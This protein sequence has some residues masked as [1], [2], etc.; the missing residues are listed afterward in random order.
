M[1]AVLLTGAVVLALLGLPL[2]LVILAITLLGQD[3]VGLQAPVIFVEIFDRITDNPI[4][5]T[6]PLFAH[7]GFVLSESRAPER[8]VELS[9]SALGFL[10]GGSSLVALFACALFTAFTGASGVT[11]IALGGLLLPLL[12]QER[13]SERFSLG[14]LTTGGSLGLLFPPSLPLIIFALIASNIAPVPVETLFIAGFVPGLLLLLALGLYGSVVGAR[15]PRQ[16]RTPFQPARVL[17]AVRAAAFELPVPV[18]V[19]GGIFGGFL[20]LAQAAAAVALYVSFVEVYVYRDLDVRK[21]GKV[22]VE[23]M[24]MV[25]GVLIIIMAALAMTNLLT[26]Q[27]IPRRILEAMRGHLTSPLAFLLFLNLF[28]LAV[29][30]LMDIFSAILVVVPL[31]LP[32][33]LDFGIDPVHLGI[34]ILANLEIGYSTPPV[35]I[36]LFIASLRFRRPVVALYSASLPFLGIL[37]VCLGFITYLP[38][39]S[40]GLVR[41]LEGTSSVEVAW[42]RRSERGTVA[43]EATLRWGLRT[44]EGLEWEDTAPPHDGAAEARSSDLQLHVTADDSGLE[45]LLRFELARAEAETWSV[46]ARWS[47]P[48]A[49]VE[50]LTGFRG[51]LEDGR[52]REA[53]FLPPDPVIRA[54]EL[55]PGNWTAGEVEIRRGHGKS[56]ARFGSRNSRSLPR[57]RGP[58]RGGLR[59]R[60][61]VRGSRPRGADHCAPRAPWRPRADRPRRAAQRARASGRRALPAGAHPLATVGPAGELERPSRRRG[62]GDGG[63]RRAALPR[64]RARGGAAVA[65]GRDRGRPRGVQRGDRRAQGRKSPG[66]APQSQRRGVPPRDPLRSRGPPS[67]RLAGAGAARESLLIRPGQR[68]SRDQ[69]Q[70]ADLS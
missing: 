68:I 67:K 52:V 15:T 13:Y 12:L 49:S 43:G 42:A 21:L 47:A 14:L 3:S 69:A 63:G 33:A 65:R 25:G 39:L 38:G 54:L 70:P 46:T 35:G 50:E 36:N 56:R 66:C 44:A 2:F 30:C 18:I 11:I 57:R 61:A 24:V 19:I 64:E 16:E 26:D 20:T 58:A 1:T 23:S 48:G 37:L 34:I 62:L 27:E 41:A 8:L 40:L 28:L 17:R 60:A 51:S 6:I 4:F 10:P 31:V 55:E 29:G 9:R 5:L 53:T 7:A 45:P 32:I 59:L 22:T